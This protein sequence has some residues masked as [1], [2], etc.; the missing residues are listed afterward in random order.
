MT[1]F[2]GQIWFNPKYYSNIEKIKKAY[3]D[4]L[5]INHFPTGTN[6]TNPGVH[7]MGHRL[8]A[9]VIKKRTLLAFNYKND[10][11]SGKTAKIIVDIAL[12][13]IK[14]T[15]DIILRGIRT[16]YPNLINNSDKELILLYKSLEPE[17]K[18]N[19]KITSISKYA[20]KNDT[21]TLAEAFSDVHS[22]GQNANPI[23]ISIV[24]ILR[25]WS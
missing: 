13:N 14:I 11:N 4:S 7:E 23:S 17:K 12:K 10:W 21:E 22:N 6:W 25:E 18:R 16:F 19:I 20:A 3:N 8:N 24:N 1:L 15:D 9:E 5:M 2:S